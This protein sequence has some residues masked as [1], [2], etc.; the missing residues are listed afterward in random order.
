[1]VRSLEYARGYTVRLDASEMGKALY[2]SLEFVEECY[3]ERWVRPGQASAGPELP[4]ACVD[5][6]R[7]NSS[8]GADR[9]ALLR[10]LAAHETA[11][12]GGSYAFARP[13]S[14]FYYFGPCVSERAQDF[15]TLLAWCI[16]R[17]GDGPIAVDLFPHHEHAARTATRFNFA[18]RRRLT[19][20]VLKPH[21]AEMPNPDIYAI[22]GFEF[23]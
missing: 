15:E 2:A 14:E 8:F 3:V 23:G 18:P 1:M 13:G 6:E 7:D 17:H 21:P 20:M 12:A 22:A 16:G 5:T 19:R 9:S 10:E 11:S 4:R